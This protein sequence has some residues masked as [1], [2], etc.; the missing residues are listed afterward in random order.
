VLLALVFSSANSHVSGLLFY[1][2]QALVMENCLAFAAF[3]N[4]FFNVHAC[5]FVSV[6]V[7]RDHMIAVTTTHFTEE[8]LNAL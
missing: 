5:A 2:W 3:R 6:F 4:N 8:N 7:A 1:G